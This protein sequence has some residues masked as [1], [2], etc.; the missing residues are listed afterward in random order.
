MDYYKLLGIPRDATEEEVKKAYRKAAREAHPD[1]GG[2]HE[3]MVLVGKAGETLRDRVKRAKYDQTGK[4]GGPEKSF[5]D[6]AMEQACSLLFQ[7]MGKIPDY[8]DHIDAM[9]QVLAQTEQTNAEEI[10]SGREQ[11]RMLERRRKLLRFKA[12]KAKRNFLVDAVDQQL[13]QIP[14]QI[15]QIERHTKLMR[16]A[17]ELLAD[18]GWEPELGLYP[19]GWR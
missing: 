8:M 16:R 15:E 14:D 7:I 2:S 9:R 11:M 3:L 4:D 12:N 1:K 5:D 13:R 6:L 17:A 19:Q 10:R 18:Y